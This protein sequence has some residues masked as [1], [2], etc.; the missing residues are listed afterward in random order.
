MSND[1][2]AIEDTL[3]S[4]NEPVSVNFIFYKVHE[5]TICFL[6]FSLSI[7]LM[8]VHN[9]TLVNSFEKVTATCLI[10]YIFFFSL[11]DY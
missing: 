4:I 10:I 5:F 2:E 3:C 8:W 7:V 11:I 6:L 9:T 1:N